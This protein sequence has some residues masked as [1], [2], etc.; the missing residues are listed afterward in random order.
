MQALQFDNY[1]GADVLHVAQ[2]PEPHAGPGQVRVLVQALSVN[3]FDCKLRAGFM[4]GMVPVTFPAITGTDAAGV[5]DEVGVGVTGLHLGDE[6]FGLGSATA[7]ELAVLDIATLKPPT[8]SFEE[9]AAMGLAVEAAA[10]CL[11]LLDLHPGATVLID[12]AAGGVGSAMTQL[13]LARGLRVVGT[14]GPQNHDYLTGLGAAATTYGP[15]LAERVAALAPTI[16]GAV[17]VVGRGSVPELVAI[18]GDPRRVVTLADFTAYEHGVHVA[19]GSVARASYALAEA[20]GLHAEGR[21]SMPIEATFALE[22]GGAA[23][24]LSESGHLRGKIVITVP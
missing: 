22:D 21:F 10:R 5:V 2:A 8:L 18:T 20:A 17:D 12:G 15:G 13:A 11:D 23:Q 4:D 3:P 14:A 6:V 1:G 16:D 9:A 24:E 7:A 19:D